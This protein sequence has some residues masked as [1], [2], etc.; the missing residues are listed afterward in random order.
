VGDS[1]NVGDL[2][3]HFPRMPGRMAPSLNPLQAELGLRED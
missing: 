2:L 3:S 1:V